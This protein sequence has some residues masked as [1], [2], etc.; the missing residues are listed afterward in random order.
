[1]GEFFTS[2]EPV[3]SDFRTN[4]RNLLGQ[5]LLFRLFK[6]AQDLRHSSANL[7]KKYHIHDQ[8]SVQGL[9]NRNFYSISLQ[10][11]NSQY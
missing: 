1:M 7:G 5:K 11:P 9:T 6:N 4:N 3:L 2:N 8:R 10:F